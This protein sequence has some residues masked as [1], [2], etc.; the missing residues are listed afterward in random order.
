MTREK[1]IVFVCSANI[2][3]SPMAELIGRRLLD[4]AGPACIVSSAGT[5]GME[6]HPAAT[7]AR[8]AL[9]EIGLD[10]EE[11]RS[12]GVTAQIV[13][14]A[15]ALVVMSPEHEIALLGEADVEPK[16]HRSWEFTD[17]RARLDEIRDPVGLDLEAFRHCR[18]E[19][20]EC[21]GNW[22]REFAAQQ[23]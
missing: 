20:L 4:E 12:R 16:I 14:D 5:L 10:L 2:C 17:K 18:D 9:F 6:G 23:R 8:E 7:N 3:R 1:N 19:L 21:V 13:E 22:A 11:H 15:D